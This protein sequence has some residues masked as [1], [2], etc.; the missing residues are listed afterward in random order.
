[1]YGLLVFCMEFLPFGAVNPTEVS[2]Y[3]G[4]VREGRGRPAAGERGGGGHPAGACADA[5]PP[6]GQQP[7]PPCPPPSPI[8]CPPVPAA[9]INVGIKGVPPGH[10]TVQHLKRKVRQ[11]KFWG[12][13]ALGGLAVTAHLFDALCASW[14][15]TTLATTSLVIIVGAVLQVRVWVG[16][17]RGLV[18][19]CTRA[20]CW[21]DMPRSRPDSARLLP[22]PPCL[23]TA[24]QLESTV[25]GPKLQRQLEQERG[26]IGSLV[27]L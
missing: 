19:S 15:G 18:V 2:E 24:R 13:L 3:F 26:L 12:G 17:G 16:A 23:Q 22:P 6:I 5:P 7:G 20:G 25:Q 9:Q 1:M 11:A 21:P 27:F 4:T 10:E 8:P 14:L